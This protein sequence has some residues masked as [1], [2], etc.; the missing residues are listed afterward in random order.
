[1]TSSLVRFQVSIP[2]QMTQELDLNLPL[3]DHPYIVS[4]LTRGATPSVLV[5]QSDIFMNS[6]QV[7]I[8][9]LVKRRQTKAE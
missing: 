9:Q 6:S 2:F 7:A 1:M 5:L 3:C 8:E 4:G